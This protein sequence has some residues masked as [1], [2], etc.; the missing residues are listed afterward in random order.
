MDSTFG[1]DK[2]SFAIFSCANHDGTSY[3]KPAFLGLQPAFS[4]NPRQ[5]EISHYF[6]QPE[7]LVAVAMETGR[8]VVVTG[9]DYQKEAPGSLYAK[10]SFEGEITAVIWDH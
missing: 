1:P 2:D 6:H 9:W 3:A 4:S 10:K 5:F 8:D 7:P